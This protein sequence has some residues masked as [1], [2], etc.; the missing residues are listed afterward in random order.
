MWQVDVG[1]DWISAQ[2]QNVGK[3]VT[4]DPLKRG[5]TRII[6]RPWWIALETT[7]E[8]ENCLKKLDRGISRKLRNWATQHR[9]EV[10]KLELGNQLGRTWE[11]LLLDYFEDEMRAPS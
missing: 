8:L 2:H 10:N 9:A 6:A 11:N 1:K 7:K 4:N 3:Q 5:A